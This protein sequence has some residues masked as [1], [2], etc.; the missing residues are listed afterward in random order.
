MISVDV[1]VLAAT[2]KN[3]SEEIKRGTF[4]EDLLHRLNVIPITIPP[5]RERREDIPVLVKAFVQEMCA[6]NGVAVKTIGDRALQSLMSL[7]WSGNIRELRNIVERLVIMSSGPS[8]DNAEV[9]TL[10]SPL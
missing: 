1:R 7:E 2:N 10:A 3:L 5:L 4:R 9:E 6:R 8:I